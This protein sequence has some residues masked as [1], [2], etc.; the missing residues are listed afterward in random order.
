MVDVLIR[1]V[2]NEISIW[3][4]NLCDSM[5]VLNVVFQAV[6]FPTVGYLIPCAQS[7]DNNGDAKLIIGVNGCLSL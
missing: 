7:K 1:H 2:S 5:I 6:F 3:A 4:N